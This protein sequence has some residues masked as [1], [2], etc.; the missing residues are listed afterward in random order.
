MLV[1]KKRFEKLQQGVQEL[2]DKIGEI[3][4]QG[5]VYVDNIGDKYPSRMGTVYGAQIDQ[6][7]KS[8]GKDLY[9]DLAIVGGP[10]KMSAIDYCRRTD[11]RV[12]ELHNKYMNQ[13]KELREENLRLRDILN[14]VVDYVY[15]EE[16]DEK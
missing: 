3:Q 1:S 15:R 13:I 16:E 6:V 8:I 11:D 7:I 5:K 14:E 10:Q 2:S 4:H 12:S 9:V